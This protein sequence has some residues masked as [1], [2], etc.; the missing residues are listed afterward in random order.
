[1]ESQYGIFVGGK[2]SVNNCGSKYCTYR[3][4]NTRLEK[5]GPDGE[6]NNLF[7]SLRFNIIECVMRNYIQ[8][9]MG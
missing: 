7:V 8:G 1:V 6:E 5:F 4:V 2:I 3:N 9:I